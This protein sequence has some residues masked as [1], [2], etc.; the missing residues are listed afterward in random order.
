MKEKDGVARGYY[1]CFRC[2]LKIIPYMRLYVGAGDEPYCSER[3]RSE[4]QRPVSDL[5][6]R[7]LVLLE[8]LR[9][10]QDLGSVVTLDGGSRVAERLQELAAEIAKANDGPAAVVL[11]RA[12]VAY[13]TFCSR[14]TEPPDRRDIRWLRSIPKEPS[15]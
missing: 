15:K 2:G 9:Q 13:E 8:T 1:T 4:Q 3:C 14:W 10:F 5:E 7:A 6:S 12:Y 11:C